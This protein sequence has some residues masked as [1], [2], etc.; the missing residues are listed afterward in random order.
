MHIA[1]GAGLEPVGL[2]QAPSSDVKSAGEAFNLESLSVSLLAAVD[3][4]ALDVASKIL[5]IIYRYRLSRSPVGQSKV[6]EGA[7][8]FLAVIYGHVR[9]GEAVPMCLPA[10]PFKSPNTSV[11]VLGKLPDRAE[12]LALAHLN[13]LCNAIADVYPPGAKLTIISDG[14]VYNDLLGVPDKDVW[15]YGE[16]LRALAVEKGYD[17]ILFSRLRDL[18]SIALPEQ[19]DE[20]T[21][22]ANASNFRRTLLN[23]FSCPDWVWKDVSQSEDVCLTYR[24]YIKFLETDLADV[25]PLHQGRSKSRYKRGIE[26]IAKE[27]MARGDAFARAVHQKYKDHV[28]LS[29]HPST[30]AAKVSISLLPTT[31]MYTTPWHCTVGFK[32]DG[33]VVSGMRSD[34]DNDSTMELVHENGRPSYFRQKSE[35]FSWGEDKGGVTCEPIYPSGWIIRPANGPKAMT[36]DDVDANKVRSL[37][38]INSPVIMRGFFNK[39]NEDVFVEKAKQFGEPLP[40][41]FGLVLKVKDHG[42]D[43]RGLNNVLSAEWMPFHYDGLFKTEKKVDDNGQETLVSTPPQFQFF[44]GATP[45]PRHTGFTIFSSSTMVFKHLPPWITAENLAGKTWSVSTS[46]FD[47]TVLKGLPLI[48]THPTTGKPCLRYHE[49]WP[50]SKTKFEP[51]I[52]KIEGHDDVESAAICEAIDSA[53][54]DRRVAYFHIWEKGDLVVSDNILMMHT[55]S[56]FNAGSDREL[57]RI[58]FDHSMSTFNGLVAEF[59]DIRIDFFRKLEGAPLPLACFLSH[60]HSDHL[61]GLD[62]LWSPFVYCSA[63]TRAI[64]LRLER[65]PCRINYAQGILEARQQT[66]KH[67]G[68]VLKPLPLETP[69]IIELQPGHHIQVTLFDA[70]HCPGAVMFLIEGDGKAVMYTGDIRS[71]PWFVNTLARNP[72]LIEY[73]CGLKTLDKIY[74]DTSFIH[75]VPFQTKSDGIAELLRKVSTYP[76]DTVFHIQAWTYG[77]EE[78]WI[79]LSKALKCPIHVDDYKMRI[80]NALRSRSSEKQSTAEFHIAAG[81]AA[82]TGHM[83]GN[84]PHPGCLTSDQNVRLHSCEKGNMCVE[85]KRPGVVR[86]QPI[87]ARL[88]GGE[89]LLEAGV[90]GG[91]EDLKREAELAFHLQEDLLALLELISSSDAISEAEQNEIRVILGN[92]VASGRN[93]PLNLDTSTFRD[94]QST[95]LKTA[96]L[97]LHQPPSSVQHKTS[98]NLTVGSRRYLHRVTIR[99]LLFRSS[100]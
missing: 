27:M 97:A 36:I 18:V 25:Y 47:Q 10:F 87:V 38:E 95:V 40:W 44:A 22:V 11:K 48:T 53:L 51:T 63:A 24:G 23:T 39:P 98:N 1:T 89:K 58:H 80:Y 64:L 83:C 82:L 9:A 57:W 7:L 16:A 86:I 4:T 43:T 74:L 72:T 79:A 8:K 92:M 2:W 29:I 67:L 42:A 32:L 77:Y 78:V 66:Y 75:N 85:A 12:E 52:V 65:Y 54:H 45:S 20:M 55:R 13:G 31:S 100:I 28:R 84:T 15:A 46:S 69:T 33:T 34:F 73:A 99:R 61:A 70:N 81:A 37:S 62:S 49:P 41:K 68:K 96:L 56:D 17:N 35:L 14:L 94:G 71:E 59:P 30:G 50:Q 60:V 76:D 26:Y 91:G 19:L 6:D 93:L 5:H 90:G 88:P 3:T 21:Y